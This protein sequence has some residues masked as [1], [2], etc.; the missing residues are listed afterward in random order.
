MEVLEGLALITAETYKVAV[1][2]FGGQT[3]VLP[4]EASAFNLLTWLKSHVEKVP[5]MGGVVDFAA[6]VSTTN[7]G[8]MLMRKGCTH[9]TKVERE[10]LADASSLGEASDALL[11][12]TLLGCFG[13]FLVER[14]P[15]KWRRS[16]EL[17]YFSLVVLSHVYSLV[18]ICFFD[19]VC[20]LFF[21]NYRRSKRFPLVGLG[22][23][24]RLLL[25]WLLVLCL[26][27]HCSS[28]PALRSFPRRRRSSEARLVLRRLQGEGDCQRLDYC[29][30]VWR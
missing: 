13:P 1:E 28:L 19:C 6:L 2:K 21:R 8:K 16:V 12:A 25:L 30:H 17:R 26:R 7:F 22:L 4:E 15:G 5:S 14:L 24:L 9:A 20:G 10:A 23:Y 3:S 27:R 18:L 11:C 29:C